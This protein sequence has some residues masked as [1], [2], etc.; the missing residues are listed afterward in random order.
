MDELNPTNSDLLN[1]MKAMYGEITGIRNDL[2]NTN[3]KVDSLDKKVDSLDKKV[4]TL[5]KKVDRIEKEQVYTNREIG[6]LKIELQKVEK[7]LSQKIDDTKTDLLGEI[8][9]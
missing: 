2:T 4:D 8:E 9:D 7:N 1:Y 3:I 6:L 5:D